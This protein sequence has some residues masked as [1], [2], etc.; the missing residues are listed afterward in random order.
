MVLL[1]VGKSKGKDAEMTMCSLLVSQYK[2][3]SGCA[4]MCILCEEE[5]LFC[6]CPRGGTAPLSKSSSTIFESLGFITNN[7]SSSG[8][9]TL[10]AIRKWSQKLLLLLWQLMR[11]ESIYIYIIYIYIFQEP[12]SS[13]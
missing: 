1:E 12:C 5:L 7:L 6:C 9:A 11:E 10:G 4:V 8:G 13:K 2:K 3:S